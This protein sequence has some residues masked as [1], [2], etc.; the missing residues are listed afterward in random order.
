VACQ[1]KE[2]EEVKYQNTKII[3]EIS[4]RSA[5]FLSCLDKISKFSIL[6][7]SI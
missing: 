7:G 4:A 6:G 1:G 3:L 2:K 5:V